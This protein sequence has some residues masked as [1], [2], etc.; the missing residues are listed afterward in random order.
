V[1]GRMS[2]EFNEATVKAEAEIHFTS[3]PEVKIEPEGK[4][5]SRGFTEA[6][7]DL[8]DDPEEPNPKILDALEGLRVLT[9]YSFSYTLLPKTGKFV[10]WYAH[11]Q[12]NSI[13][14]FK[15]ISYVRDLSLFSALAFEDWPDYALNASGQRSHVFMG[16]Q[17]PEESK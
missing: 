2:K 9:D 10:G 16:V 12:F 14:E 8:G 17:N 6:C 1:V 11:V 5:I 7:L 15:K 3:K 4:I 13:E